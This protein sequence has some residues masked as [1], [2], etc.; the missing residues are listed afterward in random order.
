MLLYVFF[1]DL[2][3]SF[4]KLSS[5]CLTNQP[6]LIII[7]YLVEFLLCWLIKNEHLVKSV[8]FVFEIGVLIFFFVFVGSFSI[9]IDLWEIFIPMPE[10]MNCQNIL[11][12]TQILL[13]INITNESWD[14][15]QKQKQIWTDSTSLTKGAP[16]HQAQV[17]NNVHFFHA[18]IPL[19]LSDT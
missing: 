17:L 6:I 7:A 8:L 2:S 18:V 14:T 1:Y 11:K 10:W 13:N 16:I 5:I 9:L 12:E 4:I 19:V 15:K 3:L